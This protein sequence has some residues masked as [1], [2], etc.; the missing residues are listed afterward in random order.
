MQHVLPIRILLISMILIILG[1]QL[2]LYS[3]PKCKFHQPPVTSLLLVPNILNSPVFCNTYILYPAYTHKTRPSLHQIHYNKNVH[4]TSNRHKVHT[5]SVKRPADAL[6][7]QGT[8]TEDL[9]RNIG[10]KTEVATSY[11]GGVT[12]PVT[13]C[14]ICMLSCGQ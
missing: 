12:Q 3:K 9:E 14:S 10:M 8:N 6:A 2:K 5:I 7:A 1:K 4:V 11:N 13:H